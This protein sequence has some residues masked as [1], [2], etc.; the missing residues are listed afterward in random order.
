MHLDAAT[1]APPP[2]PSRA[3]PAMRAA[4]LAGAASALT[5]L[6]LILLPR[7][8][9]PATTMEARAARFGDTLYRSY[10]LVHALHPLLALAAACAVAQWCRRHSPLLA[11]LAIG[12]FSA[13]AMAEALQQCMSWVAYQRLALAWPGADAARRADWA[14]V[15]TAYQ[16]VW[17]ALY[18]FLVVGFLVGNTALMAALLRGPA[19]QRWPALAF[20]GAAL[21]TLDI[22]AAELGAGSLLSGAAGMWAYLAIQPAARLAVAL[23]LWQRAADAAAPPR[24]AFEATLPGSPPLHRAV[25]GEGA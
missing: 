16:V 21:L 18:L 14:A 7:L 9:E 6:A 4:A 22:V 5:T 10:L 8:I 12:G 3:S 17:D 23:W 1:A 19:G 25:N 13:W 20:A 11:V 2:A 15:W 24:N